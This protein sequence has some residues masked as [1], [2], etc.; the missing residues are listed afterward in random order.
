MDDKFTL[1]TFLQS[2]VTTLTENCHFAKS[3]CDWLF[4]N[5]K[6]VEMLNNLLKIH[7]CGFLTKKKCSEMS[8]QTVEFLFSNVL[9]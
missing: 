2:N 4:E 3:S 1:A 8:V 9:L 6:S 5:E 7:L